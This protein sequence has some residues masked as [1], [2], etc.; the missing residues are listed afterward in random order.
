MSG[1][2]VAGMPAGADPSPPWADL[3][4][5]IVSTIATFCALGDYASCR[6]VCGAWRSAL[7]PPLSR[8]LAVLPADDAA[9]HPVSLVA[10]S[11]HARRWA[12]LLLHG[13]GLHQPT[14]IR[15][16][17]P[18]CRCVGASR[19]GW[20]ALVAGDAAA[21]KGPLLFNPF[22]GEEIPLD[23]SLYQPTHEPAPKIVFSP[24]PTPRDFTA[25]SLCRPGVVA[26]QRASEYCSY[27]EDTGPLLDGVALVD[28]AYG[29]DD[30][31]KVYCLASD[32]QV[33]VLHL[34]R[35]S[36]VGRRMP[37]MEVGPLPRLPVGA[38][39]FPPPYDV[40]SQYADAKNL[41]LCDG[42]LYQIWRRPRGAG[43][44]TVDAPPGGG[45]R[46]IHVFEGD[47]FV[48]RYDPGTWLSSCWTVADGKDLRGNAVFVGMNDA[49]VVRGKGVSANSVYYW[50]GPRGEGGDYEPVVYNMETGASVRWPAVS[51][52]GASS[53]VW[54][55]L[56]ATGGVSPRVEAETTGVEATSG[57]EATS[58]EEGE[59]E[60]SAHCLKKTMTS[61]DKDDGCGVCIPSP[62]VKTSCGKRS[63]RKKKDEMCAFDLLA[64]V[65]GT[66]LEDQGN[67][68]NVPN[69]SGAAKAKGKKAVKEEP[70][71]ENL[72]LKNMA[73]EKDRCTGCVVGSGGICAFPRQANNCSAEN[74]STRK[75]AGSALESLTVKSNML[76][77][78]SLVSCTRPC[79]TSCGLGIIP[80]FGAQG[81]CHPGSSI[82]AEAEQVHLAEP[83]VVGRQDDGHAVALHS[84][85]DSVDLDGRPPALVSS[86]S[87][88]CV[89]LCSHDKEHQTSSLCRGEV[90]CTADRYDDE[91]SSGCT[92]PSTT[93]DKGYKPQFLVKLRI[94]S[95]NIPELFINVPE[96]ATI[97]LLKRTVMDV[98]NTI[99]KGGLRVGVLLQG[100]DI[101]DDNKTLRQAGI[102]HDKKLNNID[103]TLEC[104]G[105][106]DSPS[107][108]IIP[109][110]MDL[111]SADVVEPLARM[112]CEG[113]FPETGGD[114]NKQRTPPYRSRS[115]S[116]LYSVVQPV[117]M[118]SQ[119]TSASS[120]AIIPVAPSDDG[121]LAIVPLCSKPRRPEI[122]K[123][124]TRMPFTVD[125]VE[126]LVEAVELIG[127]GRWRAV[128]MHAF[129][130]VEHRTYVDLK[131]KWKTLV[132]TAS[133]S[134]QQRR[135]EPVPQELLDRV[136]AAQAYWSQ[137][138]AK[139]QDKPPVPAI[140]SA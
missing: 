39:G 90:Q 95:F 1:G 111:L 117:E 52:G 16:D 93:G 110:Q 11:L 15:A 34:T 74:S 125:E 28:V 33:H 124:R 51:T 126:A 79:E 36:R 112:K 46:W 50:N 103:F 108:A 69:P 53:P 65:A 56:P 116:D 7:P 66:L 134:P 60:H 40:I 3:E 38:D 80:E 22:T 27:T 139:L 61:L 43:S 29:S 91:N 132:H 26:V 54:Y 102:C 120:Q 58:A 100:K 109:E 55:F 133:I 118:A 81:I 107:G 71:D 129:D 99:M 12:R 137:Q 136:L 96:N 89:P 6:A 41:V 23:G 114:D 122:G 73:M 119:D 70:Y 9:G 19:D 77:R 8:P 13:G 88:T 131:D 21:P 49:A 84:L 92:H 115:L 32:G 104:E 82:S 10:C 76:A 25:V 67:S 87:S 59:E 68:A 57:E 44:V 63:T 42:E 78:D 37:P 14:R 97:G 140:C 64:T 98:V 47:V 128:K 83:K 86:D 62:S 4:P 130:H 94:K 105:G 30:D 24:G 75:E 45:A 101:Q 35:R 135:G 20:V 72:P 123:R 2:E 121:A 138:Q 106:Q 31:G 17:S 18:D 48:L 85:L 127:T 5:G 113:P